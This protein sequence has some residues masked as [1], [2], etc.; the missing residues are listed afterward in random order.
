M[1]TSHVVDVII[2]DLVICQ[3]RFIEENELHL[4]EVGL[5]LRLRKLIRQLQRFI[6][7]N[8]FKDRHA[9]LRHVCLHPGLVLWIWLLETYLIDE[10]IDFAPLN[11]VGGELNVHKWVLRWT[12]TGLQG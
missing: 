12:F 3:V 9:D 6:V 2:F 1:D 8:I 5:D 7:F 4:E 10:V 11:V